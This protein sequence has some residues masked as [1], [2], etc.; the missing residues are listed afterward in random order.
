MRYTWALLILLIVAPLSA[1]TAAKKKPAKKAKPAVAMQSVTGCVDEKTM[2]YVLRTDDML[3]EVA[4][5]ESVG[6]DK[7]NFARFVG[8]KVTVSG[9]MLYSGDVPTV[10]VSSLDH[11]KNISDICSPAGETPP[12]K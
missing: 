2:E 12:P 4:K 8:H 5:L 6:F 1:Q 11:I 10:R 3:K 9:E 7:T